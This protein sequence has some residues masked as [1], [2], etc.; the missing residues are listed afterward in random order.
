MTWLLLGAVTLVTLASRVL[1]MT[2]LP[3]PRGRLA[4][5]LDALPAPLFAS[6]AALALVGGDQPPTPPVLLATAAALIG[7]TRRS[8][9]LTLVCGVAGFA[10]GHALPA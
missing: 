10:L 7:A 9:A 4:Q 2:L 1:P 6:L 8:L 3:T 5:A